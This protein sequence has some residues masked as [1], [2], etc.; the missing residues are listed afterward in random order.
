MIWTEF[1]GAED[2]S[3]TDPDPG[4]AECEDQDEREGGQEAEHGQAE[5]RQKFPLEHELQRALTLVENGLQF[6]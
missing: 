2:E 4:Q 5:R 3:E 1:R 6:D